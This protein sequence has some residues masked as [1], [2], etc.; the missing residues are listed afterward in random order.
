[1]RYRSLG[2]SGLEV[3]EVGFGAWGIGGATP[4]AT[5]YGSTCDAAS[6]D[7]LERAF[8]LGVNF[9]DTSSIYGAGHSEELLGETFARRRD[10]VRIATKAGRRDYLG[11]PDFSPSALRRSLDESLARLRTDYVDL[12][13][14]H[15]PAVHELRPEHPALETLHALQHEG[16]I[17]TFGLSVGDPEEAHI[18]IERLAI[19]VVQLNFNLLDQRPLEMGLFELAQAHGTGIIARTPLCFGVLTGRVGEDTSFAP[20][21]HRSAWPREQIDRWV[22]ASR[23]FVGAVADRERQ[24]PAQIALRFCL[25]YTAVTTAIPGMLTREQVE[26]NTAASELGPLS[27]HELAVLR[28]CYAERRESLAPVRGR[29]RSADALAR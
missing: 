12:L 23:A 17:R 25:S 22:G 11:P 27:P 26:E 29:V 9:F 20:D 15:N 10:R 2:R 4:G 13:Q 6:R 24:T 16:R 14:L 18:A 8:E 1:M 28:S 19:P 5:S 7:A 21:D 3:S